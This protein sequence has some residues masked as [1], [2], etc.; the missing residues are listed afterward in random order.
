[1][2]GATVSFVILKRRELCFGQRCGVPGVSLA[3]GAHANTVWKQK[4]SITLSSPTAP[5]VVSNRAQTFWRLPRPWHKS[6]HKHPSAHPSIH[7][8]AIRPRIPR[9]AWQRGRQAVRYLNPPTISKRGRVG[10]EGGGPIQAAPSPRIHTMEVLR[11]RGLGPVSPRKT[12]YCWF[13]L[14]RLYFSLPSSL[15]VAANTLG[16]LA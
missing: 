13:L 10:G 12:E 3:P 2:K 9:A 11:G 15:G 5:R 1:M 6:L 8:L 14:G 7:K 16:I 4:P